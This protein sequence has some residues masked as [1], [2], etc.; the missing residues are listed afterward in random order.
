MSDFK[1]S[2]SCISFSPPLTVDDALKRAI[3]HHRSGSLQDA[4]RLYRA[5]LNSVPKHPD[6]NHNLGVLAIQ[7]GQAEVGLPHLKAALEANPRHEQ[8]WLSYIDALIKSDNTDNAKQVLEQGRQ[9]GLSGDVF[10]SLERILEQADPTRNAAEAHCNLG[11]ALQDVGRLE[12]AAASYRQAITCKPD[13]AVAHNNLGNTLNDLGCLEEAAASCRQAIAL[14]PDLVEAHN[15]LGNTLN[16]LERM[17]EAEASYRRA[18]VLKPDLAE[19]HNNLGNTLKKL[20]RM[21]EAETSYRRAIALKPDYAEAHSNLGNV[22]DDMG[23]LEEAE[24]IFRRAL[25]IRPDY[26]EVYSNLGNT[27]KELGR[28]DEAEDSYR[29]AIALKPYYAEAYCNLGVTLQYIGSLYEAEASYRRAIALKP[30]YTDAHSNLLFLSN[31]VASRGSTVCLEEAR[32]YGLLVSAKVKEKFAVWRCLTKPSW[33]RIG[34]ISG[35]L[36]NH[37]VGHFLESIL[38]QLDP[39]SL[40]LMAYPTT[41]RFDDLT[42]RIRP[43]FQSWKPLVGLSDETAARLI[44]SDG[45]HILLDL[46]GHTAHNRLPVFAWKPAPVQATWLGYFAT[47]GMAEMDYL[48]G[49]PYNTPVHEASNFT[50]TIWRLPE[51]SLCFTPPHSDVE[52]EPLPALS[53]GTI[54]FGCFNNLTKMNDAVVDIWAKVLRAIPSASLFIKAKQLGGA[55]VREHTLQRFAE[56]GISPDRLR[57]E[58]FSSRVDYLKAY[59]Q[60]DIALDPF[61]FP[62]GTTSAEGLWMGVPVLT[63]KGDCFISHQ[64]ESIATNAGLADWIAENDDDYVAKAVLHTQDLKHLAGLR[65]GLRQQVIASPLFDAPSFA[66]NL[67]DALWGMWDK[68]CEK[69]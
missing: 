40:A 28:P 42:D 41:N 32:N 39:A 1:Q 4:E 27:L 15:N 18:I 57:L 20:G 46:A 63:K 53:K 35:D 55:P 56:R 14:K 50:E 6:A 64:G 13:F 52:I 21:E 47:T 22:L 12:E 34:L 68:W 43:C 62:G 38:A 8:Y 54:T 9:F 67:Q 10:D 5:I 11:V 31:Y 69:S 7:V 33:L 3:T 29:R 2:Q 58:E 45:V 36:G 61:P 44:H 25:K 49:D 30:D 48:L 24:T 17:E 60:V 26:A 65:A 23:R 37:P 66:R 16:G 19:A 51:I 59:N